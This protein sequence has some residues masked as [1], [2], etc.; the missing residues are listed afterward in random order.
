[1]RCAENLT[2]NRTRP[3]V[4]P[5]AD[6]A[7]AHLQVVTSLHQ[8]IDTLTELGKAS[9]SPAPGPIAA[10]VPLLLDAHEAGRL[11]SVSRSKVL[12]L[13]AKGTIPSIRIGGSVRIPREQLLTWIQDRTNAPDAFRRG[14]LPT[15]ARS[16][17]EI[18][19]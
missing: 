2:G 17:R 15:W 1:M 8:L 14:R 16:D 5:P 9:T 4:V 12:E 11:M 7:K 13:A 3:L 10:D 19:R 18:E 6:P